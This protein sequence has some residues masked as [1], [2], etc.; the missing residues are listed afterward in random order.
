MCAVYLLPKTIFSQ[1]LIIRL[2][3]LLGLFSW[4]TYQYMGLPKEQAKVKILYQLRHLYRFFFS[5][6][7]LIPFI[8]FA[9]HGADANIIYWNSVKNSSNANKA[10]LKV[11][12]ILLTAFFGA[13]YLLTHYY[14]RPSMYSIDRFMVAFF[15]T[16]YIIEGFMYRMS[17]PITRKN[18]SPLLR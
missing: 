4:M 5:F 1:F 8:A 7:P 6:H 9:L 18:I 17:N 10:F 12:F 2:L 15:L 3:V 13:L 11:E 16:H 14:L